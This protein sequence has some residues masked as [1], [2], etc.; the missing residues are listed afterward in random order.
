MEVKCVHFYMN[1]W[2]EVSTLFIALCEEKQRLEGTEVPL[3]QGGSIDVDC[4]EVKLLCVKGQE[5]C[6]QTYPWLPMWL[7]WAN[8]TCTQAF[9]GVS[10]SQLEYFEIFHC[11][12][13]TLQSMKVLVRQSWQCSCQTGKTDSLVAV[14]WLLTTSHHW[15][16]AGQDG[17]AHF[18]FPKWIQKESG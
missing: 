12:P 16:G 13:V 10:N 8:E 4:Q 15:D 18:L 6:V 17:Q 5:K 9:A 3:T 11:S 2:K 14:C 7:R 1:I